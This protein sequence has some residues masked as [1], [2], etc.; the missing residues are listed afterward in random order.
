[1]VKVTLKVVIVTLIINKVILE[2][3]KTKSVKSYPKRVKSYPCLTFTTFRVT[4]YTLGVI[5]AC[6]RVTSLY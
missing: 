3:Y 6:F 2:I 4:L 1:M 5:F